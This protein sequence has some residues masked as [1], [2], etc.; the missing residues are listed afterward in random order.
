M[1]KLGQS[2]D[3]ARGI[4]EYQ[5]TS[6]P[7]L[8]E[9]VF[10]KV[11]DIQIML[12]FSFSKTRE[13]KECRRYKCE[14]FG[15]LRNLNP[16]PVLYRC[17]ALSTELTTPLGA[18]H[19]GCDQSGWRFSYSEVI[20]SWY[21]HHYD[22]ITSFVI[23]RFQSNFMFLLLE[24]KIHIFFPSSNILHLLAEWAFPNISLTGRS[25]I[26]SCMCASNNC[27]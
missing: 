10:S 6:L 20:H 9:N 17:I 18:G 21:H 4:L 12:S 27:S 7:N 5:W 16:W 22:I 14:T 23:F 2:W 15:F 11:D 13:L 3:A 25:D 1:Q 26:R 24:H 19:K 8:W